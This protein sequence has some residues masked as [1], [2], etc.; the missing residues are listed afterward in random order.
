MTIT[1]TKIDSSHESGKFFFLH[2]YLNTLQRILRESDGY[3]F[4][5]YLKMVICSVL[6]VR[7]LNSFHN[8]Q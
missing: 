6:K 5:K 3:T 8:E 1:D 7:Y 4:Q 2:T